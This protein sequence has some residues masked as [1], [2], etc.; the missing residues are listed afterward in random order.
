MAAKLPIIA[1]EVGGV[2]EIV[3]N[4]KQALLVQKQNPPA[5]AQAI[6]RMLD[7]RDLRTRLAEAALQSVTAYSPEAYCDAILS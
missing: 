7:D 2:P 6:T 3:V 5:L 1:T 4:E